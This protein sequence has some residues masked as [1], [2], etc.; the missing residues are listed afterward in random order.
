M[1][2]DISFKVI[3]GIVEII[4]IF[5]DTNNEENKDSSSDKK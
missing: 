3:K 2:I 1:N 4:K 5:T